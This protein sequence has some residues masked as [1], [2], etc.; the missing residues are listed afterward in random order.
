MTEKSQSITVLRLG[1]RTGRDP[2]ISTHIGLTARAFG[3]D[4]FL[5]AGD[6]D[7]SLL[8][9]IGDVAERF[10]GEFEVR[11]EASPLGF[12]RNFVEAGG[13]A[14]HLTM[15]GLPY[16][17]VI[18]QLQHD[19]P[20]AIVLGGAKVPR[21]YFEICQHNVAV[22][23]QPHSEV[24]ALAAFLECYSGGAARAAEFEGG[25]LEVHPSER[26]KDLRESADE[27]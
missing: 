10:G 11:H 21:E 2:R 18:P 25:K 17:D 20:L 27:E 23:N 3:A 13:V 22:G 14:V 6:N 12:L 8:S 26:G 1:H 9:G 5:L 4:T 24:A 7:A 15:Y 16:H 19:K